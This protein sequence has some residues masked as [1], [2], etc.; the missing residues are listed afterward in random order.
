VF[1]EPEY[2]VAHEG[3]V[4]QWQVFAGFNVQLPASGGG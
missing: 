3:E 1:V 4:P 2:T